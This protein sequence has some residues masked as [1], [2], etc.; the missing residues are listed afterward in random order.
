MNLKWVTIAVA[1]IAL[2]SQWPF[3]Q[4]W[5]ADVKLTE[6]Y[7]EMVSARFGNA[8]ESIDKAIQLSPSNARYYTWRAYCKSQTS[9]SQCPRIASRKGAEELDRN[10]VQGAI[11]D[12]RHALD[13]NS[14]DAV[15]HHNLAWLEHLSG[16][17]V[18]AEKDWH[19][20]VELD[21]ETAVFH[22]SYG[23]FL[24]ESG[25]LDTARAQYES[26]IELTP[27]ILDSPFFVRY[28]SH[29]PQAAESL[30]SRCIKTLESRL[31]GG[32]DPILEARMGKLYL[33][34]RTLDRSEQLLDDAAAQLP[35]LPLVWYNLGQVNEARGR[36]EEAVVCYKKASA[37]DASLAGPHLHL[38]E[39]NL[40]RGQRVAAAH[41][42]NLAV[43]RWQGV[44]PITAAHN[45]RL[46]VGPRQVIDDLLPTTLVWYTTP[47][48]ASRAWE[49]LAQIF[50]QNH[51]YARRIHTCEQL[52]SPHAFE[53]N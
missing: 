19:E 49:G 45:N 11:Q 16:D 6:F 32:N 36:F 7:A 41:D 48:E 29:N 44:N 21:P 27:S 9:P 31:Q 33:Y 1:A 34:V 2:V 5:R 38:G 39:I 51:E 13:L 22:L 35:N 42:L 47:C 53:V 18:A 43:Q 10:S 3:L 4:A 23:M 25:Q 30:V 20:A 40:Q 46:Y 14:R 15:A 12:Y 50:P 24:E 28:R 26:A 8:L 37:I 17:D 52:P